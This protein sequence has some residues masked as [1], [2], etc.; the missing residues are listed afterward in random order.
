MSAVCR[1]FGAQ[2]GTNLPL[3][4]VCGPSACPARAASSGKPCIFFSGKLAKPVLAAD[5]APRDLQA[6][7][8]D[9]QQGLMTSQAG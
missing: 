7:A 1:H 4:G 5:L 9:A 6:D 8:G 3:A 2:F